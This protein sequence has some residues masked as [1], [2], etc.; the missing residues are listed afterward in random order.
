MGVLST[1]GDRGGAVTDAIGGSAG[2]TGAD[3]AGTV[4][5]IGA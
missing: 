5:L 1:A 2:L 3:N 4:G